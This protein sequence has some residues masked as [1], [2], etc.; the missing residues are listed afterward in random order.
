M[1]A[2]SFVISVA[3]RH[4]A[5]GLDKIEHPFDTSSGHG[6]ATRTPPQRA[7][8]PPDALG[9]RG[10]PARQRRSGGDPSASD[11]GW[12]GHPRCPGAGD[13]AGPRHRPAVRPRATGRWSRPGSRRW[14]PSS[15]RPACHARPARP[16][17]ATS[18]SGKTTLALR[19]VAEAQARGAIV[20]WLDLARAFDPVEAVARGVDLRWLLVVRP[21]D[22]A[23]GFALAGALLSGRAV[24]LL[25]VDLPARLPTR[26]DETLRRLAAHAR[27]VGARLIV[28]EPSSLGRP[29]CGARWRR[30]PACAWSSSG[31]PGSGSA[32][33]WSAS[34][35]R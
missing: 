12:P 19:C 24:D 35:R 6:T 17:G 13:P 33:T 10:R 11:G 21:G 9:E 28:L 14:T 3:G 2:P 16:S 25:V 34:A 29:A 8:H 22:A 26:V 30:R 1:R 7:R 31:G 20:A 27:R 23:E 15:A 18:S 5:G 4:T 32:G